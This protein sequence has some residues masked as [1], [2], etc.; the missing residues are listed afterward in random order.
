MRLYSKQ[1]W[2]VTIGAMLATAITFAVQAAEVARDGVTYTSG[3]VG[4]DAQEQL[5]ARAREFNLKLV[6]TLNEGN[7]I[8]GVTV[9]A[10]PVWKGPGRPSHALV[11][12][13]LGSALKRN[14]LPELEEALLAAARA[15]SGQMGG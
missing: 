2:Q 9:L 7:Y 8:A 3:G 6:F 13:G 15:L 4:I 14:G 5:N 11:A 12:I 1:V 10:A